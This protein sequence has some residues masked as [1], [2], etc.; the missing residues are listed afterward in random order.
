MP[1]A[2]IEFTE[3]QLER[4]AARYRAGESLKSL[5]DAYGLGDT[6]SVRLRLVERGVA[7]RKPWSPSPARREAQ[8]RRL[9]L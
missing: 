1:R 3:A 8:L 2:R 4:M 9:D 5:A 7:I 6:V